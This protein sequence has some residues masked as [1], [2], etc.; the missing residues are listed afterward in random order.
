MRRRAANGKIAF[1]LPPAARPVRRAEKRK[2]EEEG[3][4]AMTAG[5]G[6]ER[7]FADITETIGGT[8]LVRLNRF[9]AGRGVKAEILAKLEFLNPLNSV[10]DRLGAAMIAELEREGRIGPE[11]VLVEA[12]SGNTGISLAFICAAKGIRAVIVMPENMSLERQKLL[13]LLGAEVVLTPAGEGMEG[14]V[15][16]AEEIAR[17]LPGAVLTRQ[18]ENPVNPRIHRLTTGVEIWE[19]AGGRLDAVVAGVGTG[20]TLTGVAQALKARDGAVRIV[21]VEPAA[22]AVLSGGGAG[23]HGIQGI[24]AGFVPDVLDASLIDEVI[25]VSDAEALSAARALARLEGIPAGISSGAAAAAAV[26]LGRREEMAGRRIVVI[27]ASMA[28][29]YLSTALFDEAE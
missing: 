2:E 21:A 14:A 9:P 10:K 1:S 3:E 5:T 28:E 6:R 7:I 26:A 11:T 8:P 27:M 24:G 4:T 25:A 13:R 18:F 17:A 19:D 20:G 29:R 22:S 23:A 16:K 15:R 12:T